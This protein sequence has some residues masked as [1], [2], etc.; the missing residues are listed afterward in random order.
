[1][2][3]SSTEAGLGFDPSK[4]SAGSSTACPFCQT[5]IDGPYVRRYGDENGFGQQLMCVIALNPDGPGK[6]YLV[7]ESLADRER[8]HQSISEQRAVEIEHEL[9]PSSL[10]EEIP[11][12]G[13]A[14]LATGKSYLYGIQTFRQAFTPRQ[15]YILLTM[16][17]EARRAHQEML[18]Q[19]VDQERAKAIAT[20]LGVWLSRLTDRCNGLARWDNSGEKIQSLTSLKRFA[21]TWDFPEVNIFGGGSGDAL[22]QLSFITATVRREGQFRNPVKVV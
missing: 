22:S 21:M 3:Q 11:P 1:M 2:V 13:N 7:D 10:D 19:G 6:L 8:E 5:A 16:A 20:Y 4:G 18:E 9:G 17:R 15:R 14:G 12:T